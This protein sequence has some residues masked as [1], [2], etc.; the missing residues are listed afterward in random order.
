MFLGLILALFAL[1]RSRRFLFSLG[2]EVPLLPASLSEANSSDLGPQRTI[3]LGQ[4]LSLD[5][6]GPIIVNTDGTT[7]RIANWAAL[8]KQEQESA[9]KR[10]SRRNKARVEQLKKSKAIDEAQTGEGQG[11][12]CDESAPCDATASTG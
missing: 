3:S 11:E 4:T 8:T 6:L 10:I 12:D 2:E 5:D 7:R 1:C 9:W